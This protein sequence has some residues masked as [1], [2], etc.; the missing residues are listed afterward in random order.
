[1]RLCLM[2]FGELRLR[3]EL[4][5]DDKGLQRKRDGY[6]AETVRLFLTGHKVSNTVAD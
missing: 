4:G 3:L 1:M 6:V 5:L 2:L